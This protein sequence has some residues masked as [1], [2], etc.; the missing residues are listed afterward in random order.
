MIKTFTGPMFSGKTTLFYLLILR[1][2]IKKILCV[3]SLELILGMMV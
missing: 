1:C 3:L 2:G